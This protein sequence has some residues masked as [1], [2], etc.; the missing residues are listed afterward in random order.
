[1][2]GKRIGL[3]LPSNNVVLEP[4]FYSL[5]IPKVTFHS[6]RLLLTEDTLS[7]LEKM[8]E[9]VAES[10][11]IFASFRPDAIAFCCLASSLMGGKGW[12]KQIEEKIL[13]LTGGIP[14]TV[15]ASAI[16]EGLDELGLRNIATFS[17]Y[18]PA[19]NSK[20]KKFLEENGKHVVRSVGLNLGLKEVGMAQPEET[21]A[22]VI[23]SQ[24][25]GAD[26][27]LI[28]STD[29]EVMSI[30]RKLEDKLGIPVVSVNQAILHS[31]LAK[32]G[33]DRAVPGYGKLLDLR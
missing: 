11:R 13:E 7:G 20:M 22:K 25:E 3:M 27:L 9:T 23:A 31:V 14:T 19:T 12:D 28:G 1:M 24:M 29:L 10:A 30:I 4:E 6:D 16:L 26:G 8:L 32:A 15:A 5:R 17:A 2:R 33:A 21:Y 18:G